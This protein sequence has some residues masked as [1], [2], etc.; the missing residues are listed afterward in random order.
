MANIEV[1]WNPQ[2][3]LTAQILQA[4][5][6]AN[7]RHAQSQ[8]A[9]IQQQQ[10]GIS[11]QNAD[12]SKL[13]VQQQAPHIQAETDA[14]KQSTEQGAQSFPLAL[15]TERMNNAL[16]HS[17][18][19]FWSNPG[20]AQK[21][22]DRVAQSLGKLD[23][24]FEQP[25]W[26]AAVEQATRD[27][28]FDPIDAAAK[29][30]SQERATAARGDDSNAFKS[31]QD[32]F[33]KE[34]GRPPTAKEVQ[35]F[36]TAGTRIRMEGFENLRQDNYIDT[37]VKGGQIVAMTAGEFA[38][39]NKANPGTYVKATPVVAT[40]MKGRG[41]INDIRDG[42]KQMEKAIDNPDFKLSSKGRALM[43]LA[44]RDPEHASTAVIS[45]LAAGGLSDAEQDYLVA[46][47]SLV[48]RSYSLRS[49]QS[50]GAGSESSREAI[51][52]LAPG[53][54]VADKP[55]AHKLLKTLAN[56]VDN[57]DLTIPRVGKMNQASAA[58]QDGGN[59]VATHRYNPA[60]RQIEAIG[61]R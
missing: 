19:E 39:A 23:P 27:Q 51:K 42:M 22:F 10:V 28:K 45:G 18:L 46:Y 7:E 24:H 38:D 12:T 56:N 30:I 3:S 21:S 6:L 11:Q 25:I 9:G 2:S 5:Q 31:W 29:T 20:N 8:Q 13:Q 15:D 17:K 16:A 43:S 14:L 33:T 55:M 32:K 60:T 40:A 4:I 48:E 61:A 37:S 41:F 44:T 26:D 59:P 50:Q 57:L 1:P 49:L 54:V 47:G 36:Q 34:K 52:N 58:G 35:D 53:F